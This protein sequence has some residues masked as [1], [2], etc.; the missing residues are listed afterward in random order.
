MGNKDFVVCLNGT[1]TGFLH[2]KYFWPNGLF[3][4][5]QHNVP[6]VTDL[7]IYIFSL[8]M[9]PQNLYLKQLCSE[10]PHSSTVENAY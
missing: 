5:F 3:L 6:H 9:T 4:K 1:M 10:F 2:R 7:L 8:P